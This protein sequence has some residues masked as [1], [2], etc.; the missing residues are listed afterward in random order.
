MPVAVH[1]LTYAKWDAEP[2]ISSRLFVRTAPAPYDLLLN[3]P[4]LALLYCESTSSFA[5]W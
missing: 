2:R 5:C 3:S 1:K 4:L